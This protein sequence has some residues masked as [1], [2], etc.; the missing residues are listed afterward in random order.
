MFLSQQY[1]PIGVDVQHTSL[2]CAQFAR[3]NGRW[4]IHRLAS[5]MSAPEWLEPSHVHYLASALAAHIRANAFRRTSLVISLPAPHVEL[6][7][8]TVPA[9]AA[10]EAAAVRADAAAHLN[11]PEDEVQADFVPLGGSNSPT[12]TRRDVL[13]VAAKKTT[14]VTLL[15]A[16]RKRRLKVLAVDAAP[17]AL[18]RLTM[19]LNAESISDALAIVDVRLSQSVAI[20]LDRGA[21]VCCRRFNLGGEAFLTALRTALEITDEEAAEILYGNTK[22]YLGAPADDPSHADDETRSLRNILRPTMQ[23]FAAELQRLLRYFTAQMKGKPVTRILLVGSAARQSFLRDEIT[24]T[25]RVATSTLEELLQAEHV[26]ATRAVSE[27]NESFSSFGLA[28]GLAL[29]SQRRV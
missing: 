27:E 10:N 26:C 5:A 24:E 16:L 12:A 23:Q 9:S 19:L 6:L 13:A 14:L 8:L 15:E 17:T 11:C 28:M 20:I 25:T 4:R 1:S 7:P 2:K 21:L 29:R 3:E 22:W 18:R